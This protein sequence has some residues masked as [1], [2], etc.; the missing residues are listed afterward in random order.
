MQP[1]QKLI[2]FCI[3]HK[4]GGGEGGPSYQV[5]YRRDEA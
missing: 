2:A 1:K 5:E 4:G 3:A